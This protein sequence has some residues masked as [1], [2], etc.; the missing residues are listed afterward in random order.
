MNFVIKV[1]LACIFLSQC[2]HPK[3]ALGQPKIGYETEESLIDV[4][5]L[6]KQGYFRD[7]P[8]ELGVALDDFLIAGKD[9]SVEKRQVV[10]MLLEVANL[11]KFAGNESCLEAIVSSCLKGLGNGYRCIDVKQSDSKKRL[12]ISIFIEKNAVT[13]V[14]QTDFS[15]ELCGLAVLEL[16]FQIRRQYGPTLQAQTRNPC[17]S[18]LN[19]SLGYAIKYFESQ[20]LPTDVSEEAITP[21][22]SPVIIP[23]D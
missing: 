12:A 8:T 18:P 15:D 9:V 5:L 11:A 22:L 16:Q 3:Q 19:A 2:T 4:E 6:L 17:D 10:E 13:K 21:A 20:Q 1:C 7:K 23:L 14:S